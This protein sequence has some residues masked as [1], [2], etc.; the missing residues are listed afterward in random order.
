[1][2]VVSRHIH[3]HKPPRSPQHPL[4]VADGAFSSRLCLDGIRDRGWLY[5]VSVNKNWHHPFAEVSTHGLGPFEH[6][7]IQTP[8]HIYSSYRTEY[9]VNG[10]SQLIITNVSNALT[11]TDDPPLKLTFDQ[12]LAT[13]WN[14]QPHNHAALALFNLISKY[15]DPM[16]GLEEISLKSLLRQGVS[17]SEATAALAI[18][19]SKLGQGSSNLPITRAPNSDGNGF[20][21]VSSTRKRG[22]PPARANNRTGINGHS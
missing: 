16:V 6:R 15:S 2:F 22:R 14:G 11:V 1:M 9:H 12:F 20:S 10:N 21:E 19:S 7:S 17:R 5:S 8:D 4:L 13:I 18:V 3:K